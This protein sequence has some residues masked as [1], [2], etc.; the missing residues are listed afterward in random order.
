MGIPQ[1]SRMGS[2]RRR[3][4][5]PTFQQHPKSSR[6]AMAYEVFTGPRVVAPRSF[7]FTRW[8]TEAQGTWLTCPRPPSWSVARSWFGPGQLLRTGCGNLGGASPS[9]VGGGRCCLGPLN[10]LPPAS[11]Q[12]P[13]WGGTHRPAPQA[14]APLRLPFGTVLEQWLCVCGGA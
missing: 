12:S 13:G 7:P 3:G 10:S 9:P 11:R 14:A 6:G 8:E 5:V 4:L 1:G 2:P